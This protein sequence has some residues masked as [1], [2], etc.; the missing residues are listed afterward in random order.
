M[1]IEDYSLDERLHQDK[2]LLVA[3][4]E[5]IAE[6][7]QRGFAARP[8][9]VFPAFSIDSAK[10]IASDQRFDVAL[11]IYGPEF[12]LDDLKAFAYE[13]SLSTAQRVIVGGSEVLKELTAVRNLEVM[14]SE[15]RIADVVLKIALLM[16]FQRA[17]NE[18]KRFENQIVAQ[19]VQLRDLTTRF[20]RE[21]KEACSIQQSILPHALP[22]SPYAS[23]ASAYLPMEAV[24]GDFYD[25]F[26][27][28]EDRVAMFVGD[29][30]GHGLPAAFLGSMTKMSTYYAPKTS[31]KAMIEEMN[32]GLAKVMP[33][34]RFVTGIVAIYN[35]RTGNLQLC[36]AGHPEPYLLRG[37]A[38][39]LEIISV[40]GLPLGV[41]EDIEYAQYETEMQLGDKLLLVSDGLTETQN[42]GGELLGGKGAGEMFLNAP[43]GVSMAKIIEYILDRQQQFAE[44]RMIKDDVTL[45]GLERTKLSS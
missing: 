32:R 33:D 19:N 9:T 7:Y 16:R 22:K 4:N 38:R 30:T 25:V 29:V 15:S 10:Q 40:P 11:F 6:K 43:T 42:M 39:E 12:S 23:F 3:A 45:I 41:L 5:A 2:L 27:V 17:A 20:T 14:P 44:G 35:T 34:G 36:R 31:A 24:G 1:G 37:A 21:L 18:S 26:N 13:P 28:D 8:L